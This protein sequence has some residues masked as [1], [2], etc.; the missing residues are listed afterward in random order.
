MPCVLNSQFTP[1]ILAATSVVLINGG[2]H[3]LEPHFS[4]EIIDD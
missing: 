4:I 3:P 2:A 1:Q